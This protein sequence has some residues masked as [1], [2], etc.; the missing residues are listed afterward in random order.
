M[1]AIK[2]ILLALLNATLILAIALVLVLVLLIG[3]VADLRD[4]TAALLAPQAARL[5]RIAQSAETIEA[6][7][8]NCAPSEAA[9]LRAELA[10][11]RAD[12]PDLSGLEGMTARSLAGDIFDVAAER[13]AALRK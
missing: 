6:R 3:R 12:M 13:L 1:R 9:A 10:A 8:A 2:D 5:E 4:G 11:L 7:L